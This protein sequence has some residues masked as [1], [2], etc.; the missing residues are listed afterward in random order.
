LCLASD[1]PPA[2]WPVAGYR[3]RFPVEAP[4]RDLQRYGGCWEQ[5]QVRQLAHVERLWVG[6]ALGMW[7]ALMSGTWR[8]GQ[9][10]AQPPTGK[11]RTRPG[12]AKHSLFQLGLEALGGGLH[13]DSPPPHLWRL[14]DWEAPNGSAH[15]SAHHAQACLRMP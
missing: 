2:W 5:G 12:E 11:R 15:I 9:Y 13:A 8:A 7:V 14:T 6:M 3:Q 1:L 10:L 4:F